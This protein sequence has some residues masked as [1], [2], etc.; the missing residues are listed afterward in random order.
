[1]PRFLNRS[2]TQWEPVVFSTKFRSWAVQ[3]GDGAELH[4]VA[5]AG[6]QAEE[7]KIVGIASS[8]KMALLNS[9]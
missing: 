1:M 3:P 7:M 2:R 9:S 8:A 6:Q 4:N 5:Q